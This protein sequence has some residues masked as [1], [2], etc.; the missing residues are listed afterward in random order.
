MQR[1]LTVINK[2]SV[3]IKYEIK[4]DHVVPAEDNL[5]LAS[6]NLNSGMSGQ[7][8]ISTYSETD[9]SYHLN[10]NFK[11]RD[12]ADWNTPNF[13]RAWTGAWVNET[14]LEII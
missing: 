5:T 7:H 14:I 4:D 9:G 3:E 1:T 6:G 8:Q 12:E 2:V 11:R 13:T 10:Y